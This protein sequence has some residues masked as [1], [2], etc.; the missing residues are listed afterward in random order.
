MI[1]FVCDGCGS[2]FNGHV[3]NGSFGG[4]RPPGWTEIDVHASNAEGDDEKG[5][6]LHAC[7]TACTRHTL[8][9]LGETYPK[10]PKGPKS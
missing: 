9:A 1:R 8:R 6:V 7:S 3:D 4:Q 5:V 2:V 10:P